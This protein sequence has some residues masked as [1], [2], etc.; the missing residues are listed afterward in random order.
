MTTAVLSLL[1]CLASSLPVDDT[2]LGL[3]R[4][5]YREKKWE[6]A[7]REAQ[8]PANQSAE[9]DY[10]AGMSLAHLAR[11]PEA[12]R[13]LTA[14]HRKA[15]GDPRFLVERAGVLWKLQNPRA[16]KRDLRQA[17]RLDPRDAY[18]RE[19]LGTLFLLDGNLE[20]A[21]G[22]W[23]PLEKPRLADVL[24]RPP[25][26]LRTDILDRA[27]TFH[28][29]QVLAA[30]SFLRTDRRLDLLGIFPRRRY[31]LGPAG[32]EDYALKLALAEENGWGGS[33]LAEAISLLSGLPYQTVYPQFRNLGGRAINFTSLARWDSQKRRARA[34]V[35]MPV[36]GNPAVRLALF[37]DARDEHWNLAR[38]FQGSGPV[39]GDVNLR[40]VSGGASFRRVETGR[41]S[42]TA[43]VEL[44]S[45]E[46]R[47]TEELASPVP[48]FTGSNSFAAWLKNDYSLLRLPEHRFTLDTAGQ[49]RFG[50]HFKDGLGPFVSVTGD[51]RA[52]W[53]PEARGDDYE[54]ALRLRG[55]RT[56]GSVPL[57]ELFALGVD[58]DNDL[59]MRGHPGTTGGR[60]GAAPLGSRYVLFNSEIDKV[61]YRHPFFT[62]KLGPFVDT[63]T[64][65]DD[66]GLVGSGR[67]LVDTGVQVK[68]RVLG[69]LRAAFS[70]GRD[71]HGGRGAFSGTALP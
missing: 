42:W 53:F 27:I 19:F 56:S 37:F 21:L 18:A 69:G 45:R 28:P 4:E 48:F 36:A 46:F 63:G 40:R 3:V 54:T 52:K 9:F 71:L 6:E 22:F 68:V 55:G 60:P 1:L 29:P 58:R 62:I 11:W 10:L 50:C 67:W 70:Y 64:I 30:E 61:V 12:L 43:G 31:E 59:A 24:V 35:S 49:V 23:N 2:R 51:L 38:T 44:A 66:S 39:A 14:G 5:L 17:L 33:K 8:G 41:W 47:N 34:E 13:A 16:A 65:A 7:A 57:D 32:T 15:P 26:E 25:V 20:A